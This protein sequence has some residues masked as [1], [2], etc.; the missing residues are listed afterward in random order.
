MYEKLPSF[1]IGFHGCDQAVKEAVLHKGEQLKPSLNKYD[2]LGNGVYFWEQNYER[3]MEF[4][5]EAAEKNQKLSK[6]S[7]KNPAVVGAVIDLGNC[8]NLMDSEHIQR[9][10]YAYE[11]YK[12]MTNLAGSEM[13]VNKGGPD[14]IGRYL[15]RAVIETLHNYMDNENDPYDTA[16]G[17][18]IEGDPV[19][20]G[21]GFYKKTHIQIC[22][23]NMNCI[24][25]LFDPRK[26]ISNPFDAVRSISTTN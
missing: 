20:E 1:V 18:F 15:D 8:L 24:K 7:I 3:A 4:A 22:V 23:R 10:E 11:L 9:L 19:Y 6:G 17:L 21:A 16:R 12:V 5:T 26:D 13:A 25:A 2:W 14:R